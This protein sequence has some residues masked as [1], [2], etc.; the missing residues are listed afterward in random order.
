[1]YSIS[2]MRETKV[3]II[4]RWLLDRCLQLWLDLIILLIKVPLHWYL[5]LIN[6]KKEV[7][8]KVISSNR[9]R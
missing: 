8:S 3:A 7:N 5:L 9:T 4:M 1:M 6:N 2:Q